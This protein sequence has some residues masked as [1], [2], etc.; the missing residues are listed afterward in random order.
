MS[1]TVRKCV[2]IVRKIADGIDSRHRRVCNAKDEWKIFHPCCPR[3]ECLISVASSF[4]LLRPTTKNIPWGL[5]TTPVNVELLHD[6][7]LASLIPV[8]AHLL[9]LTCY[10]TAHVMASPYGGQMRC[11]HDSSFLIDAA[12]THVCPHQHVRTAHQPAFPAVPVKVMRDNQTSDMYS[13]VFGN[14]RSKC[15]LL[16]LVPVREPLGLRRKPSIGECLPTICNAPLAAHVCVVIVADVG[17]LHGSARS[18]M[19]RVIKKR[20]WG[21]VRPCRGL[22]VPR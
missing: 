19:L 8:A 14:A 21:R 11:T 3:R 18:F 12:R 6:H 22:G 15:N 16:R 4:R 9:R 1:T 10:A 17:Y 20:E 5:G 2:H 13:I 7:W